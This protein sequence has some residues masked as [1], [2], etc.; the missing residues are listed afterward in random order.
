MMT[1]KL[2]HTGSNGYVAL[3]KYYFVEHGWNFGSLRVN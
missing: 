1:K 3:V 2:R